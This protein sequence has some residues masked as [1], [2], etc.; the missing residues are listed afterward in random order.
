MSFDELTP[1]M[2]QYWGIKKQFPDCVLLFRMGDFYETFDKDAKIISKVLQIVLTSRGKGVKRTPLAGIPYHALDAYLYK[3]VKAGHKVAI[4]EQLEDPKKAKGIVKRGVVRIVTPGTVTEDLMLETKS[5][6]YIMTF[7]GKDELGLAISD[8]STGEFYVTNILASELFDEIER[9]S[10]TE[11]IL[12]ESY[13]GSETHHKLKTQNNVV[14]NYL[15]D[16]NYW[17]DNAERVILDHFEI[18]SMNSIGINNKNIISATGGL[19]K[20]F[21]DT[22]FQKISHI[23]K[24][25]SYDP[26]Q[27]M[28]LDGTTLRNLE[29]IKNQIDGTSKNT[30]LSILNKTS[31]S[32]GSRNLTSWL[33]SPLINL[34]M[35]NDRLDAVELLTKDYVLRDNLCELLSDVSDISRISTRVGLGTIS[36]RE[37]ISLRNSLVIIPKLKHLLNNKDTVL[38]KSFTKLPDLADINQLITNS[39]IE[40]P[41]L[42]IRDGGMIKDGFSQELD[43][44]KLIVN[45]SKGWLSNFEN[46]EKTRTGIKLRVGYNRVMGYYIE[47]PKHKASSVPIDYIRKS[48]LKNAERFITPELKEKE[49]IILTARDKLIDKEIELY[50]TIIEKIKQKI[51]ELQLI[52]TELGQLDTLVTFAKVSVDNS[53]VKPKFMD[54]DKINVKNGRHPVVE[55]MVDSFVSNDINLNNSKRIMVITGSNMAGK[56]TSMRQVALIIIMAQAGCFVPADLVELCVFDRVFTRVGA[57]DDIAKGQSTFMM[58]MVETAN[59]LNNATDRSFVILDEIGR[60]TSTYD[61]MSLAWAI[62]EYLNSE[63]KCKTMFATHYHLINLMSFKYDS[64]VNYN[65]GVKE[66]GSE[67]VFL[68]KL[69]P[70]GTDKSYGVHVAKLAGLPND[71]VFRAMEIA[72]LLEKS[73]HVHHNALKNLTLEIEPDVEHKEKLETQFNI[74]LETETDIKE[75]SKKVKQTNLLMFDD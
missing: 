65:I 26:H 70:G 60:G 27:R 40:D 55:K 30:L 25:S 31:T 8:F 16:A 20:Y 1:A 72:S 53:Y 24:I 46:K 17:T 13:R 44:L 69:M 58:E 59:I 54:D 9:F 64:I 14:V 29:I 21:K 37:L 33:S 56:S 48:T 35:I 18:P 73:D 28:I 41:P 6:N 68:H 7:Y 63:I 50:S 11:I 22:Q 10:P 12:P 75:K 43:E 74:K 42:L 66:E 57:R 2:K 36:P 38:L 61:G 71:V 39:I 4:I 52:S 32:M 23:K 45:D 62:V 15:P 51:I 47:V 5:N 3:L 67:L 34:N 49:T 19:L